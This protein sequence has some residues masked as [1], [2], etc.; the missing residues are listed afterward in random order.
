MVGWARRRHGRK[1]GKLGRAPY[2]HM[3]SPQVVSD[4]EV[5]T[6]FVEPLPLPLLIFNPTLKVTYSSSAVTVTAPWI[7]SRKSLLSS[8]P[9]GW[10]WRSR[11]R[12]RAAARSSGVSVSASFQTF[13]V[14][15]FLH[16]QV[17]RM[18]EWLLSRRLLR[19]CRFE[20]WL[21][22]MKVQKKL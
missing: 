20:S 18:L 3:V 9:R 7:I 5:I 4:Y 12:R 16:S 13:N 10:R 17:G 15:R 21:G 14:T 6:H 11:R 19:H 1:E 2:I 22:Q 8:S